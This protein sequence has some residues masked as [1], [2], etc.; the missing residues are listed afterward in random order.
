MLRVGVAVA[1][2]LLGWMLLTGEAKADFEIDIKSAPRAPVPAPPPAGVTPLS[3]K[4]VK[5][6][7]DLKPGQ[8]WLQ[9]SI[10]E[11]PEDTYRGWR[12]DTSEVDPAGFDKTFDEELKSA[13]FR[14]AGP[15]TLF[16]DP[17]ETDLQLGVVIRNLEAI[18]CDYCVRSSSR[19][20]LSAE[21]Q[22]YSPLERR[23]IATVNTTGIGWVMT[24][25]AEAA[26]YQAVYEAFRENVRILLNDTKFRE[27]VLSGGNVAVQ[28]AAPNSGLASI[29]LS[30]GG[31]G[32]RTMAEAAQAVATIFSSRGHGSG[33]LVST[34]G[35]LLTNHHV[36]GGAKYVKVRWADGSEE[37]GEVIRSDSARDVALVKVAGTRRRPLALRQGPVRLGET[38][39]AI[40]TPLD[41]KFENTVTRGVVSATRVDQG[42]G[43]IQSDVTVNTGN[44]GGPLLDETGVVIGITVIGVRLGASPTGIN[45]FVPVGDAIDKLALRLPSDGSPS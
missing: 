27:T 29:T 41:E 15:E 31:A 9:L 32:H 2:A 35:Y 4:L 30:T 24:R 22:I 17:I 34:D 40:G 7:F 8:A 6:T 42:L 36:V 20:K 28:S 39:F 12:G 37:L 44:S 21:W 14:G 3:L 38:V 19:A 13:G 45:L 23:V 43:Y 1:V 10:S 16:G 26:V 18:W 5:M 25:G 33:F 11:A